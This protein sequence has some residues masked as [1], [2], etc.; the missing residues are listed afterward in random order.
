MDIDKLIAATNAVVGRWIDTPYYGVVEKN[1]QAQW[2]EIISPFLGKAP[3]DFTHTVELALG[4]GRMTEILLQRAET[5][6]GVDPLQSNIDFCAKRFA[7]NAKLTLLRNDGVTLRDIPDETV[8]FLF[9][10]DSMVHFDSDVVRSYLGEAAR[11]LKP[12]GFFF[13]H[14]SNRA[15]APCDDFQRAPHARNYMTSHMFAH[16]ACKEG[17]EV[18]VQEVIGWGQDAKHFPGLDCLSLVRKPTA[19]G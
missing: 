11:V 19:E 1:A 5:V 13:T 14:H 8:T 18:V 15:E 6:I 17:L 4:H 3:I 9:C 10:W 12:G 2:D 16:Y 7:N